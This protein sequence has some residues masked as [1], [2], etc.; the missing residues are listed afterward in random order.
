MNSIV[1][2]GEEMKINSNDKHGCF[3]EILEQIK[4]QLDAMLSHHSR[5]MVVRFDLHTSTCT[6]DNRLLSSFIRKIRKKLKSYYGL[7]RVGFV[8]AR[9]QEKAKSQHYHL[10]LFL[11]A[12]K[13][14]FPKMVLGLIEDIW[15]SWGQPKPYTPKRCYYLIHRGS[16]D[17]YQDAFYRLSYIAKQR[18][19]GYKAKSTNDYSTSRIKPKQ[20]R[21]AA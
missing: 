18:G 19:K 2:C 10:A 12:N 9:E 17:K 3:I 21:S 14:R 8:W 6:A 7:T 20:Q 11:D 4:Q 15:Q 13:V 5:I 16:V 1:I